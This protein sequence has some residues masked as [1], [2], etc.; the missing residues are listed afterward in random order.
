[1]CSQ[2]IGFYFQDR[3][4]LDGK[5]TAQAIGMGMMVAAGMSFFSQAYLAS[6]VR[7]NPIRLIT[8]GLPIMMIG[9]GLLVFAGSI[10]AMVC[11]LGVLGLGLGMV[12]PGFTAGASLTV[13]SEEQGALGGLI[14]A[15][16]AAGFVLGPIVGTS[17]YQI[18]P[19]LP[20][21]GACLLMFPLTIYV[22]WFGK[23]KRKGS[24][25]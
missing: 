3:F 16:P 12:S 18:E 17:L 15:C 19:T 11:F 6:R 10:A 1:M 24:T 23:T 8:I 2:T 7:M 4:V 5:A 20:Y 13:G 9:Y 14:S 25:P 21:I 22:W